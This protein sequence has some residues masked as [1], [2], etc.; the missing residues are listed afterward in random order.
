MHMCG[1]C[2]SEQWSEF[3]ANNIS[4]MVEFLNICIANK[5]LIISKVI[6]ENSMNCKAR[7]FW[8]FNPPAH[9]FQMIA[10]HSPAYPT[11]PLNISSLLLRR[12]LWVCP[13]GSSLFPFTSARTFRHR[14]CGE[15]SCL[16]QG[17][18]T[19]DNKMNLSH[20]EHT[21]CQMEQTCPCNTTELKF[22]QT[23]NGATFIHAVLLFLSCAKCD[24]WWRDFRKWI[25]SLS[26]WRWTDAKP[27]CVCVCQADWWVYMCIT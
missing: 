5:V 20:G 17:E 15:E 4:V 8:A 12:L 27:V 11:P 23:H 18:N 3:K 14:V 19:G 13:T 21:V 2:L 6:D 24:E 10:Q 16:V 26:A 1:F 7:K 22:L 9:C 25:W